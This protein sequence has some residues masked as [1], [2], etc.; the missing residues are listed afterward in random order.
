MQAKKTQPNLDHPVMCIDAIQAGIEHGSEVGLAKEREVFNACVHSE[1]GHALVHIFLAK[2]R[3]RLT[4]T[5]AHTQVP[6]TPEKPPKI[7][8]K[9]RMSLWFVEN[10]HLVAKL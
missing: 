5:S 6:M 2:V 4:F 3:T 8:Y 9:V 10:N 7:K 1:V